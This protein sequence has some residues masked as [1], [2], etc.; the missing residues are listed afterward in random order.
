MY[1]TVELG[2]ASTLRLFEGS[3]SYELFADTVRDLGVWGSSSVSCGSPSL[4]GTK[5]KVL[6]SLCIC[7][8]FFGTGFGLALE[9]GDPVAESPPCRGVRSREFFVATDEALEPVDGGASRDW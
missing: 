4:S 8:R 9:T 6:L 3:K 7:R 5:E 1:K 2:C